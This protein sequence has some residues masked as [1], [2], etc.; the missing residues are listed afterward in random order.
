RGRCLSYGRDMSLWPVIEMISGAVGV[1]LDHP[2]QQVRRK[3]TKLLDG[4]DD[5]D[6]VERQLTGL[7][8]LTDP[9]S[10]ADELFWA[11]RRFFEALG[12][13]RPGIAIVEDAHFA[14]AA[15]LALL[16]Q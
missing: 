12:R 11:I 1:A 16:G 5:A 3:I 2:S 8:G 15:L 6:F 7:L 9:V 14:D 4:L 10:P 13:D